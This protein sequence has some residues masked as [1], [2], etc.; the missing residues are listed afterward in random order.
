MMEPQATFTRVIDSRIQEEN[1][2]RKQSVYM[3]TILGE[4]LSFKDRAK[5]L[6]GRLEN[7][8][9]ATGILKHGRKMRVK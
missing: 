7:L 4:I 5:K 6:I 2:T 1:N 3:A 9:G 8:Y